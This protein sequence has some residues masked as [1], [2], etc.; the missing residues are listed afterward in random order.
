MRKRCLEQREWPGQRRRGRTGGEDPGRLLGWLEGDE[1]RLLWPELPSRWWDSWPAAPRLRTPGRDEMR[2]LRREQACA[3]AEGEQNGRSL[4]NGMAQKSPDK[5][6]AAWTREVTRGVL[7]SALGDGQQQGTRQ[8]PRQPGMAGHLEQGAL[9]GVPSPTT[10]GDEGTDRQPPTPTLALAWRHLCRAPWRA[11]PEAAL[12]TPV[13][14]DHPACPKCPPGWKGIPGSPPL[15]TG[16]G[17][18]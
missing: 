3:V 9:G 15:A 11:A 4:W 16:S 8:N 18:A 17:R 1:G 6:G 2:P 14:P 5:G 13:S 7:C 12:H 10:L